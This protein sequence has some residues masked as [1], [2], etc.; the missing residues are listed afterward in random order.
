MVTIY[1]VNVTKRP[2]LILIADDESFMR[3][4]LRDILNQD[5]YE[6]VEARDGTETVS[7]YQRY[8]PDLVLLDVIMPKVD[9]C[10]VCAKI[11]QMAGG[12]HVPILMITSRED[13][14]TINQAFKVG[15][16]DYIIKSFIPAVLRYRIKRLLEAENNRKIAE[17][18]NRLDRLNLI[19]EMAASIGHE[20]RNP[21]TTVRGFLQFLGWKKE[22]E[23]YKAHFELMIE[24]LDRAN[25]IIKEFLSL[26]KD[27]AMDFK[28]LKLNDLIR[29]IFPML[30]ADALLNN[31]CIETPLEDV[32]AVM[33]D[34]PSIRQLI[35]N[36]TRNA[37]EAMPQGGKIRIGTRHCA[38][39]VFL[40]VE[41]E[42][43]GI[44]PEFMDKLGTPFATLKE[45]GSGLGLAIC[46][47]I[48]QRHDAEIFV[49]SEY[50]KG[51]VFTVRFNIPEQ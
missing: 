8:R 30:Q 38:E 18:L 15:A 13:E 28:L 26:A 24:E 22:L 19:G 3:S 49:E 46:Y 27:R 50:G 42:G 21:M 39:K 33:L 25:D 44:P 14:A 17:H 48:V 34:K 7:Q 6:I 9:G 10:S 2:S 43:S 36:M 1:A 47:R 37:I 11:R 29:E 4:I 40:Y 45:T 5:G 16:D 12:K 20:V 32:P 23:N 35:L 41:D 51:T 31:C